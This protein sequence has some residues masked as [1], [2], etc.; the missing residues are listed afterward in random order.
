MTGTPGTL[1]HRLWPR[2]RLTPEAVSR[3]VLTS[4][5]Q[6][7]NTE[8]ESWSLTFA[9][10]V[11]LALG[12]ED[13]VA[14]QLAATELL[15][16]HLDPFTHVGF[17]GVR[18]QLR[19][20]RGDLTGALADAAEML[21]L[22]GKHP[23]ALFNHLPGFGGAG[24]AVLLAMEAAGRGETIIVPDGW[25]LKTLVRKTLGLTSAGAFSF[26]YFR[27]RKQLLAGTRAWILGRR[28]R[29]L[30]AW[31]RGLILADS[32]RLPYEAALIALERARLL[33]ASDPARVGAAAEAQ[34][35]LQALGAVG[36][37]ARLDAA[38]RPEEDPRRATPEE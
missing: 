18:A 20:R 17:H 11:L 30:S 10:P 5:R 16:P 9:A 3:K 24:E 14:E 38:A 28:G 12:G 33:P 22:Y 21:S 13:Q 23:L 27:P 26:V 1:L 19:A 35:R 15:V 6:R 34:G 7:G 31:S 36:D 29:A 4:A 8:H 32:L 25:T 2:Q 37:S